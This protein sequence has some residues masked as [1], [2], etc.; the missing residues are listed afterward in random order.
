[1]TTVDPI[2]IPKSMNKAQREWWILFGIA[3]AGKGAD[4]T[5]KKL[6]AFLKDAEQQVRA[7]TTGRGRFSPFDVVRW[8][9]TNRKLMPM[10]TKHKVGQYQRI[11]TAFTQALTLDADALTVEN[12][13]AIPGVGPKTARMVILYTQPDAN[14]VPLDTHILKYLALKCPMTKVPKS[15]PAAGPLY[16]DLEILFQELARRLGVAVRD[17]DTAVWTA[18]HDNDLSQLPGLSDAEKS[19][20]AKN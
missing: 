2:D 11:G 9:A 8:L 16:R 13:E 19:A 5:R 10:L 15:T 12:L 17:L 20:E 6:D 1:M 18:Y 14:C 7:A 3:V 4:Q